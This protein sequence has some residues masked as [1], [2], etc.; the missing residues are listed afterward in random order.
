MHLGG[1]MTNL[2]GK[3]SQEHRKLGIRSPSL[4]RPTKKMRADSFFVRDVGSERTAKESTQM[5]V[6]P[7]PSLREE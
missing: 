6:L 1:V 7:N 4:H 3:S 5:Q 2:R